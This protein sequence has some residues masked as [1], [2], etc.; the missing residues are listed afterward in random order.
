MKKEVWARNC[1]PREENCWIYHWV[2][3]TP[4]IFLTFLR[5]QL[6]TLFSILVHIIS[7]FCFQMKQVSI[8]L[9][10]AFLAGILFIVKQATASAGYEEI[11][12][13]AREHRREENSPQGP[14]M[15]WR[16]KRSVRGRRL[17]TF[18]SIN[19]NR[20]SRSTDCQS[21]QAALHFGGNPFWSHPHYSQSRLSLLKSSNFTSPEPSCS[22]GGQGETAIYHNPGLNFAGL[23]CPDQVIKVDRNGL[24]ENQG[25]ESAEN[26]PGFVGKWFHKS[27]C[28]PWITLVRVS[29][30]GP[31]RLD[32]LSISD[33]ELEAILSL[34]RASNWVLLSDH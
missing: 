28:K 4:S 27:L 32:Q 30:S 26:L 15:G 25:Q 6:F 14:Q 24:L 2:G 22:K 3:S 10:L 1:F 34:T 13:M 16:R 21:A 9:A 19:Q 11:L 23:K 17:F 18:C 29:T 5:S 33:R 31:W 12:E 8:L 20:F 7:C